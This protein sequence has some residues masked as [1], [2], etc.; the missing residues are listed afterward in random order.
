MCIRDRPHRVV[1][2]SVTQKFSDMGKFRVNVEYKSTSVSRKNAYILVILDT[3]SSFGPQMTKA[4]ETIL[5]IV[6][7]ISNE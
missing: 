4:K 5:E 2:S 1:K 6:D 3:S 7:V